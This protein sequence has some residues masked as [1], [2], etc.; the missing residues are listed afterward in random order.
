MVGLV[1]GARAGAPRV[2]GVEPG[3]GAAEAV[4]GG[5]TSYL[6]PNSIKNRRHSL[7]PPQWTIFAETMAPA[8]ATAL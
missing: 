1:D 3:A 5:E 8:P 7:Q 6:A 2:R 4:G